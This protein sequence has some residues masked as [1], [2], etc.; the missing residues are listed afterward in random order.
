MSLDPGSEPVY[1]SAGITVLGAP[2]LEA[3][4]WEQ[5]TVTDPTRIGEL[6]EL[7][8]SIGFETMTTGLD[9]Q[10]FGE[11]CNDCAVTACPTYIA[12]FTRR[13]A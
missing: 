9:P 3:A 12:L 10:S 6:E 11:A 8:A 13:R 1:C 5:R 7:Y 2:A 4:G